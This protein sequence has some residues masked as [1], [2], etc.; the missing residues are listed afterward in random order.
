[1][2]EQKVTTNRQARFNYLISD[3]F[4]AGICLNGSEVKSIREGSVSLQDSFVRFDNGEAYVFNMHIK[5]YT[6]SRN[7]EDPTRMRKLLLNRSEIDK[8]SNRVTKKGFTCIPLSLYFNK[9]GRVK[10]EIALCQSKKLHDKREALK[11]RDDL[12]EMDRAIKRRNKPK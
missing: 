10:L 2:A 8:L 4:E 6:Y 3:K 11:K 5:P 12:R 1:M 7:Y 9:R